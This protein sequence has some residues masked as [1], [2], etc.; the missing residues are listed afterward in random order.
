[1]KV[2]GL[3]LVVFLV[4][5]EAIFSKRLGTLFGKLDIPSTAKKAMSKIPFLKSGAQSATPYAEPSSKKSPPA[6]CGSHDCPEFYEVKQDATSY[7]LR[8]Y[9]K[10]YRWVSTSVTGKVLT[11]SWLVNT[12]L[13]ER[14]YNWKGCLSPFLLGAEQKLSIG[15]STDQFHLVRHRVQD[16]RKTKKLKTLW[17]HRKRSILNLGDPV[18]LSGSCMKSEGW[19]L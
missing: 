3:L 5:T 13:Q 16:V 19:K 17:Q 9:P 2:V 18:A 8:C 1:M 10:L 15:Q 4:S 6:F 12:V 11:W 14:G 7:T